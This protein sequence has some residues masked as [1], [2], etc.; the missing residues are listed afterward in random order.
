VYIVLV[1]EAQLLLTNRATHLCNMQWSGLSLKTR[2][3]LVCVTG[4]NPPR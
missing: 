4:R 2:A 1:K 3:S